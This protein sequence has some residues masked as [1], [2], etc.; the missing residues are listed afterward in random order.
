[1][2]L[3]VHGEDIV[4]R[5]EAKRRQ[6]HGGLGRRPKLPHWL[7]PDGVPS[8]STFAGVGQSWDRTAQSQARGSPHTQ[9]LRQGVIGPPGLHIG[10]RRVPRAHPRECRSREPMG[11]T[12]LGPSAALPTLWSCRHPPTPA[13]VASDRGG[14]SR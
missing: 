3:D 4:C 7:G 9:P 6:W 13:E 2:T 14:I 5:T 11:A 10:R 8:T 1:M 12:S